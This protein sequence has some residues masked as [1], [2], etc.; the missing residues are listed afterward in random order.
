M[1]AALLV[2]ARFCGFWGVPFLLRT[3]TFSVSCPITLIG[4]RYHGFRHYFILISDAFGKCF[5]ILFR[6]LCLTEFRLRFRWFS[7]RT[8]GRHG[9]K[10]GAK[11]LSKMYTRLTRLHFLHHGAFGSILVTLGLPFC[12]TPPTCIPIYFFVVASCCF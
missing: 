3:C 2:G 8:W 5:P 9:S 12:T 4:R 10:H 6:P 7:H 11:T 1:R